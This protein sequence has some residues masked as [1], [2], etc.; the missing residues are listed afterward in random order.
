MVSV[1]TV[2]ADAYTWVAAGI[3]SQT[4]AGYQLAT[5][6]PVMPI[7]G[8]NGTDD[9]PTLAAFQEYVA[10]DQIHYFVGGS[11]FGPANGGSSASSEISAWVVENFSAQTVDGV[12]LYDLT[13]PLGAADSTA[14]TSASGVAT[15]G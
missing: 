6:Y 2:N 9:S 12:V 14:A 15:D 8:F 7:G 4:T 3:G 1:L 13:A 10:N 11:G 5:G